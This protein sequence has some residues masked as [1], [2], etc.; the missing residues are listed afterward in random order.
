MSTC[1]LK[2][3]SP[4]CDCPI[5]GFCERHK[6]NKGEHWRK[7]C[8]TDD[9]YRQAWDDNKGPG[10][11]VPG[12]DY[13]TLTPVDYGAY[14]QHWREWHTIANP[15]S[16]WLASWIDRIPGCVQCKEDMK[17]WI[18]SNRPRFDDW[19][20]YACE[21]HNHVNRKLLK[22]EMTPNEAKKRWSPGILWPWKRSLEKITPNNNRCVLVIAPDE[23][24]RQQLEITRPSLREY[25]NRFDAQYIELN[26]N[27][28]PMWPMVNK[29]L[30]WEVSEFFEQTLY[31]DCDVIFKPSM[32][33][34]FSMVPIGSYAA[35]DELPTVLEGLHSDGYMKQCLDYAKSVGHTHIPKK[36]PNGGVLMLPRNASAYTPPSV[37]V[38]ADWCMDQFLLAYN[39]EDQNTIWLDDR[40]NW[41]WIRKDWKD[42]LD[43][44]YTIH[45]NG[46]HDRELRLRLLAELTDRYCG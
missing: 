6:V 19:P 36:I 15:G 8:Q 30:A 25:A 43:A 41:G 5:A 18:E 40:Y 27:V 44:A 31:L 4:P 26:Q 13:F 32:P 39:L 46:C 35:Q 9:K 17:G 16:E 33:D 38:A 23:W 42:G 12:I 29:F 2:R 20:A 10:Q 7:L 22:N 24:S 21:G 37:P 3:V 34:L 14:H 28:C 11:L 1:K 45:L